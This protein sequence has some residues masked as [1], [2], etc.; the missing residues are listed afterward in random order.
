MAVRRERPLVRDADHDARYLELSDL[1]GALAAR[2]IR[3]EPLGA[4]VVGACG[5]AGLPVDPASLGRVATFL[6]DLAERGILLGTA[7]GAGA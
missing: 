2:L 6:G 3:H 7:A 4:A 1:A 5:E